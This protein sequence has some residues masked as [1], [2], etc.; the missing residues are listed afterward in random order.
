VKIS[1]KKNVEDRTF[2]TSKQAIELMR[3]TI[4]VGEAMKNPSKINGQAP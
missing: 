4:V 1:P 2:L 3:F